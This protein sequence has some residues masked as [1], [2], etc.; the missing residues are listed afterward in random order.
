M[1]PEFQVSVSQL[2]SALLG[3]WSPG[4]RSISDSG[5]SSEFTLNMSRTTVHSDNSDEKFSDNARD[6]LHLH[7]F[8]PAARLSASFAAHA[9]AQD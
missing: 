6:K 9:C 5:V 3:T 4:W 2:K 7:C 8:P 1:S